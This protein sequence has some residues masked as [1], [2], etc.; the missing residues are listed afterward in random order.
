[1]IFRIITLFAIIISKMIAES[2]SVSGTVRN[3]NGE[4]L[5]GANVYIEGTTLGVATD[6]QGEYRIQKVPSDREYNLSAMYIGHRKKTKPFT[7]SEEINV[8]VD[9]T[10]ILSLVD[11]D[12]VVVAAS[13]SERKKKAQSSPITIISQDDLKI[14]VDTGLRC[15]D[16]E[17]THTFSLAN[18]QFQGLSRPEY[19]P[20]ST[21]V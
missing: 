7:T 14:A 20:G 12:E 8:V 10:L 18:A 16:P 1:M 21:T 17:F 19:P 9:F 15:M 11:L 2:I 4:P 5:V 13:F 3:E 6:T